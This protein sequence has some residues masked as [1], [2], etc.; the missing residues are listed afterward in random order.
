M[1]ML[2]NTQPA[3]FAT[4]SHHYVL[5]SF[6][7][8][9]GTPQRMTALEIAAMGRMRFYALPGGESGRSQSVSPEVAPSH[10]PAPP[11]FSLREV[12]LSLHQPVKVVYGSECFWE[13]SNLG[14]ILYELRPGRP[15]P[16]AVIVIVQKACTKYLQRHTTLGI[17]AIEERCEE[18]RVE[19]MPCDM[20]FGFM[21]LGYPDSQNT[22]ARDWPA[23]GDV[24]AASTSAHASPATSAGARP[25]Q[26]STQQETGS[27][28]PR[29]IRGARRS[30]DGAHVRRPQGA[31][32]NANARANRQEPARVETPQNLPTR[33]RSRTR[34]P[35]RTRSARAPSAN[36]AA[37]LL[38]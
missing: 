29:G 15:T 38:P 17:G 12:R 9:N 36:S 20:S 5:F 34:S 37:A 27:G 7:T 28:S 24:R 18:G 35:S 16:E 33:S 1:Q 11:N 23:G 2:Q 14:T 8:S 21:Q 4:F 19:E 31:V 22:I 32:D 6:V 25:L 10:E 13:N 26:F 3:F 30:P